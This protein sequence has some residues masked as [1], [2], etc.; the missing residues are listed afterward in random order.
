MVADRAA[1]DRGVLFFIVHSLRSGLRQGD[2]QQ[3]H[4]TNKTLLRG[5]ARAR[6][7]LRPTPNCYCSL[8]H[9]GR[10]LV[11]Q[12]SQDASVNN[13]WTRALILGTTR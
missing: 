13:G 3:G 2:R 10:H 7:Q 4:G 1:D 5:L 6:H 11:A 8:F 12:L 9:R